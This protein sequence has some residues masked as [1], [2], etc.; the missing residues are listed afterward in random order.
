MNDQNIKGF[1][2]SSGVLIDNVQRGASRYR[3]APRFPPP[4]SARGAFPAKSASRW[5]SRRTV[6]YFFL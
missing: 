6:D 5:N 3:H 1:S 4:T 2:R